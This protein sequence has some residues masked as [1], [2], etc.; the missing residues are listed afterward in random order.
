[1]LD[2]HCRVFIKKHFPNSILQAYDSLI[3]KAFKADLFRYCFLYI[4]GG[5]YFD[6]KMINRLALRDTIQ[7]SDK[8][9]VCSDSKAYGVPSEGLSDTVKLYNAVICS[10]AREQRMLHTIQTAVD[11][12]LNR[13]YG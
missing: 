10:A 3:P 11:M 8:L 5:C 7:V 9:L 13:N 6:N 12:I 1:M 4:R 2:K